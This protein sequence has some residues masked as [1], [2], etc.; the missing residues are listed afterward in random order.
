L[1]KAEAADRARCSTRTIERA[2]DSGELP[3]VETL[4]KIAIR[5]EAL[6]AWRSGP[7]LRDT[8]P[9]RT[10]P[11]LRRE[12]V[13]TLLDRLVRRLEEME[14]TSPEADDALQAALFL[15]EEIGERD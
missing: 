8:R 2:V 6:D 4:G 12:L 10:D 1:T 15:R 7:G 13:D 9:M 3:A 11:G 14:G 5:A